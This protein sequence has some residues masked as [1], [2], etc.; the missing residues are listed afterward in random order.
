[1]GHTPPLDFS[2]S[3]P[4]VSVHSEGTPVLRKRDGGSSLECGV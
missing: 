2:G 1:M 4:G 3:T